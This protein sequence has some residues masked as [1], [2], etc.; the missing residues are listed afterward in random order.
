MFW[1]FPKLAVFVRVYAKLWK[2]FSVVA[3][4]MKNVQG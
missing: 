3:K 4:T 2:Y 1:R